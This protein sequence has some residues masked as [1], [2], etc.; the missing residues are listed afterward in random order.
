MPWYNAKQVNQQDALI[1]KAKRWRYSMGCWRSNEAGYAQASA[2]MMVGCSSAVT[3]GPGRYTAR[4]GILF[5]YGWIGL[6]RMLIDLRSL[7]WRT[8][9]VSWALHRVHF[10]QCILYKRFRI[11][12]SD[13]RFLSSDGWRRTVWAICSIIFFL[14]QNYRYLRPRTA[15]SITM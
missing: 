4:A 8:S 14:N 13:L 1:G 3:A 12:P 5:A 7:I 6:C 2:S 10:V 15:L 11:V 9:V